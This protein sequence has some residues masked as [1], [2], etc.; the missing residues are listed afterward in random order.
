MIKKPKKGFLDGYKT[1]DTKGGYG[2]CSEW[3]NAWNERM[4]HDLA[5]STLNRDSPL[6]VMGFSSMPS[7]VELD[8]RYREL[9]MI[10]HPDRGGKAEDFKKVQAA[11]SLLTEQ[12][13][14]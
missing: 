5:T 10:H 9:V 3:R 13:K 12:S 2:H 1:Y 4:S 8:K 7:K 6:D 11:W 14:K